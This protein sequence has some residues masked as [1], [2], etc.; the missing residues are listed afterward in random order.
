MDKRKRAVLR[1]LKIAVFL[2]CFIKPLC[3]GTRLYALDYS[4]VISSLSDLGYF[5]S[6]KKALEIIRFE[7]NKIT[8]NACYKKAAIRNNF[9]KRDFKQRISGC[10]YLT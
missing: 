8:G 10:D 1:Y 6:N 4:D 5:S 9:R 7:K 3:A 2:I